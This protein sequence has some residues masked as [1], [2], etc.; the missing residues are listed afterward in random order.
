MPEVGINVL[1]YT[2]SLRVV[3]KYCGQ[4]ALMLAILSLFPLILALLEANHIRVGRYSLLCGG[5]VLAGGVLSRLPAPTRIRS[6]EALTATT[7][8]FVLNRLY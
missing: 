1:V 5:L 6:S 2:V 7:L 8:L 3:L 4:L